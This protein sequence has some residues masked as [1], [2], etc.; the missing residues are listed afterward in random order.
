M[1]IRLEI[2]TWFNTN[3]K[4]RRTIT[5][6]SAI[7]LCISEI[8]AIN[9]PFN[10]MIRSYNMH[11]PKS[12]DSS[13]PV[14]LLVVLHGGGGNAERMEKT[15]RFDEIADRESFIVL[16]PQGYKRQ[17]ND[18]RKAG[19]IPA[20]HLNIDDV[21]FISALID[22]ICRKYRIDTTRIYVT[23][24]SN[25]GFMTTRLACELSDRLAAVAP[26][27]STFPKELVNNCSPAGPLPIMII[28]GTADPLVPYT[29]G[30]VT[31]GKKPRG[32]VLSTRATLQ[33]WIKN[34]NCSP[35]PIIK[36]IE[37]ID[38]TDGCTAEMQT[39][40]GNAKSRE[41]ILIRVDGGGH[42]IPG[43]TQYLPKKIVGSVCSDFIAEEMIWRFFKNH[44]KK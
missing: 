33:F 42:T 13:V 14:P 11:V 31:V 6:I 2:V 18:G 38:K 10:G 29:G 17:W 30:V 15:T 32:E 44:S 19:S 43:G 9:F 26:V 28:N 37:D 16:Y 36:P 7:L 21:G 22:S 27:I 24:I 39:Y 25:G 12:I 34:N 4:M 40:K 23:G 8:S 1:I 20:Q 35:V 5:L 41:V 3:I